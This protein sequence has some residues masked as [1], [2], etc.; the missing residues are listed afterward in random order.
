LVSKSVVYLKVTDPFT[1]KGSL[2]FGLDCNCLENPNTDFRRYGKTIF[3]VDTPASAI[4]FF[5]INS[6]QKLS[7]KL[8]LMLNQKD[9]ADFFLNVFAETI[10]Y[11]EENKDF[12]R[13]DF[14]ELLLQ[15]KEKGV[16]SF[17]EIAAESFIFYVGGFH[18]SA[19]LMNFILYE[20]AM[21]QAVQEELR[22]EIIGKL[23]E[24]GGKLSYELLNEMK[25]LDMV[26]SEGLRK[27]PPI[28]VLTRK[29]TKEYTIPNSN[30]VVPKGTQVTIPIY[31][32]QRDPQYFPEPEKFDP[33]RFSD[34]NIHKIRPFTYLPFGKVSIS[35]RNISRNSFEI[36]PRRRS[37]NLHWAEIWNDADENSFGEASGKVQ[38]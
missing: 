21:N 32:L 25:Y 38:L 8:G 33:E 15:M 27:Y 29:C 6:F 13:N 34:K 10:R 23:R 24:N 18:T 17:G 36:F 9:A 19:S 35:C 4:K 37:E 28:N 2:A 12:V 1:S 30:L 20:L 31:S 7:R 22:N 26:V 3:K 16:L 5:F 11:R 14:V